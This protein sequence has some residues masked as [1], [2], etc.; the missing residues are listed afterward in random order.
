MAEKAPG[1]KP[2]QEGPQT[3][4]ALRKLE[5]AP[6]LPLTKREQFALAF[7]AA[8]LARRE[9]SPQSLAREVVEFTDKFLDFLEAK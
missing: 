2:A 6:F 9:R 4:E 8:I 7:G 5:F 3:V 1:A